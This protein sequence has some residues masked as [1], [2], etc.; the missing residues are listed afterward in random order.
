MA[1]PLADVMHLIDGN[2][3]KIRQQMETLALALNQRMTAENPT[4]NPATYTMDTAG[5]I[6]VLPIN[7]TPIAPGHHI[8]ANING[9]G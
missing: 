7:T 4:L 2:P 5:H 6:T 9:A 8:N 1:N 3:D